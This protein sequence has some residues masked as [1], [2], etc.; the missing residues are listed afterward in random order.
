MRRVTKKGIRLESASDL[1]FKDD[2]YDPLCLILDPTDI[3]PR[4]QMCVCVL[5]TVC[6]NLISV[7]ICSINIYLQKG[8]SKQMTKM[9]FQGVKQAKKKK[10]RDEHKKYICLYS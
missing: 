1:V 8:S 10:E 9:L 3:L 7:Y 4:L 2:K 5:G 6:K